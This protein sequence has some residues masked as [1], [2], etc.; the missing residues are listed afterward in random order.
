M[1]P[2]SAH[3]EVTHTRQLRI[4]SAFVTLADTLVTE[5]DVA[6]SLDLLTQRCIELLDVSAA[7][8]T[9]IGPDGVAHVMAASSRHA[10]MLELLEVRTES[11]P[12]IDC[13]RTGHP[14]AEHDLTTETSRWP[15]FAAAAQECGYRSVQALPLRL[16]DR[17]IGA[18]C[19]LDTGTGPMN[20]GQVD[21]AQALADVATIGILQHRALEH[22]GQIAGQLQTALS[23]RVIVEQARGVLA[24]RGGLSMDDA[25]VRLDGYARV[26]NRPLTSLAGAVVTGTVD[27]D[28]VLAHP[29]T[30]AAAPM[31]SPRPP[32]LTVTTLSS[33]QAM[34]LVVAGSIDLVTAPVLH[35]ALESAATLRP[36]LLVVD[37]SAVEFLACAGLSVLIAAHHRA[38]DRTCLRVVADRRATR[39]PLALTGV[40]TYL[41]V[42]DSRAHALTTAVTSAARPGFRS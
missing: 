18:L 40:D 29:T 6:D 36:R 2:P 32:P 28:A 25:L 19:L 3:D 41:S 17:T 23:S 21:L 15:R 8:I 35:D 30:P 27:L 22:H 33:N 34:V 13:L 16:R 42:H 14:V 39:R 1:R 4:S 12:C 38:E 37:L 26:R 10:Q 31:P 24:Q 20:N 7:G 9:L 5:F 11:G